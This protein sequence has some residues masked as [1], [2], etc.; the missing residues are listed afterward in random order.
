M[1]RL[2]GSTTSG[3]ARAALGARR[4][5][6]DLRGRPATESPPRPGREA[7]VRRFGSGRFDSGIGL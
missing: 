1:A 3:M 6:V 5:A 2:I 4:P 7:G